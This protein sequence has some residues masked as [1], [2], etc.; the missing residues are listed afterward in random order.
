M[1]EYV[2]HQDLYDPAESHTVHCKGDPLGELLGMDYFP[3]QDTL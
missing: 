3:I 1:K 2:I